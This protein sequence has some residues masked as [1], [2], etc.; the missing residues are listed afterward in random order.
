MNIT[1]WIETILIAFRHLLFHPLRTVLTIAGFAVAM[2]SLLTMVGIGEG[3]KQK[4][5]SDMEVLGSAR[6]I[7]VQ[8]DR[9]FLNNP[10]FLYD[11][12]NKLSDDDIE[13]IKRAS[14]HIT[15]VVP[16]V[17]KPVDVAF[18]KNKVRGTKI[19]TTHEY[20]N[21]RNWKLTAGRFL[22]SIDIRNKSKV[23]AIGAEV[24]NLLFDTIDPIGKS[25]QFQGDEYT[26][27]GVMQHWDIRGSRMLNQQVII[28]ISTVRQHVVGK[29]YY[30]EIFAKIDSIEIVPIVQNQIL[31]ILQEKH[32]NFENI[33]VFSQS[34]FIKN[35][36][37][38][39]NLMSFT[40]GI[41]ALIILLIGGIGIMNLL[42][43]SV[44]ERTK[45]IGIYKAI[46]AKDSDIFTLFLIEA[47]VMSCLGGLAGIIL[48]VNGS[49][50]ITKMA[51]IVLNNRIESIIS[52]KIIIMAFFVSVILGVS[53]GIYP[54]LN[55]ARVEPG[56]ALKYE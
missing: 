55:A 25:I 16:I 41:I 10:A 17:I 19:G 8:M 39:S 12:T 22:S 50:F 31:Q 2:A 53:F 28:P 21:I 45:E 51:E 3:T 29:E 43:V 30:N 44:T 35:L 6:V 52:M 36:S 34:E 14:E 23:C 9:Q 56:K 38:S 24:K 48:G 40:F 20:A 11:E 1:L 37:Q 27:I 4:I 47:V 49:H 18:G 32:S 7:S 15:H 46:G 54:A 33:K 13:L 26:V 42:L 5:I